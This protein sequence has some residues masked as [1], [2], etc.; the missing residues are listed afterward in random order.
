MNY[1]RL[2]KTGLKVSELSLGWAFPRAPASPSHRTK[3]IEALF[4]Y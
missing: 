2:G 1:R 4:P 3:R